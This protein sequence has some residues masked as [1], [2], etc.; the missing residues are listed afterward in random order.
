MKYKD[1]LKVLDNGSIRGI[2]SCGWKGNA[3]A[4][5]SGVA[6]AMT[7]AQAELQAHKHIPAPPK[8]K[9]NKKP[10]SIKEKP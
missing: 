3:F 6:K 8:V 1:T 7:T 4:Q 2:C 10:A 5:T 9:K